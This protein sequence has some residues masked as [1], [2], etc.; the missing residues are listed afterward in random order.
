MRRDV[1]RGKVWT[2]TPFRVV[3]DASDVLAL[4]VWPGVERLAPTHQAALSS[5]QRDEIVRTVALPN[6][7]AGTWE[8][9]TWTWQNDTKLTLLIPGAYFSVDLCFRDDGELVVWYVNFE[10]PFQRT[11]IGVDTF[12]LLLDLVVDP[13]LSYRWKDEGE[14]ALGRR[15]GI[16]SDDEH[17]EVQAARDEV[18]ALLGRRIGPFDE[19]WLSWRREEHWPPPVLPDDAASWVGRQR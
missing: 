8:L 1:F 5:S 6:L 16:V 19:R 13:D 14:Y 15:L 10:R 11:P 12:D 3:S 7:A 17:R 2:A 18:L 9:T 4:A